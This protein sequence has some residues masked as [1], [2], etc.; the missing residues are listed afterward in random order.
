MS[1]LINGLFECIG[2]I[3]ICSN[4]YRLYKDKKVMGVNISVTAFFTSWG[5]WNL[6]FYPHNNLW[7]SFIGGLVI[8]ISNSI[9]IGMSI[10]Y[11]KNK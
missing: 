2:G 10:Y 5:I 4:C 7:L 6:Y 9:W 1:D 3:L 11:L 8:V